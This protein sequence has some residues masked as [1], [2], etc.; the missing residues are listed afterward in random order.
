MT[1]DRDRRGSVRRP[2]RMLR[3]RGGAGRRQWPGRPPTPTA[4]HAVTYRSFFAAEWRG[5]RNKGSVKDLRNGRASMTAAPGDKAARHG[6]VGER[7]M[8]IRDMTNRVQP[9][10]EVM[11]PRPP[12][13]V[14]KGEQRPSQGRQ[15]PGIAGGS[16]AQPFHQKTTPR[17]AKE[18]GRAKAAPFSIRRFCG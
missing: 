6:P 10:D 13:L 3:V 15:A 17:T 8:T 4:F 11:D 7:K 12:R 16:N 5:A 1:S 14:L 2:R 18:E 9:P